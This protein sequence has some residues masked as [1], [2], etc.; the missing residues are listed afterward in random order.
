MEIVGDCRGYFFKGVYEWEDENIVRG[1]GRIR[2]MGDEIED[3]D[4]MG[5]GKEW[6]F[7][8]DM[9][10]EEVVEW[11][12]GDCIGGGEEMYCRVEV[13]GIVVYE[14]E[15]DKWIFDNID[16]DDYEYLDKVEEEFGEDWYEKEL[17]GVK[18]WNWDK[19]KEM[20]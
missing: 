11:V 2:I 9:S 17:E 19:L 13:D 1:L 3:R 15:I 12:N 14:N 6:G 20:K 4:E 7:R 5:I 18:N 16:D 10:I 8:E